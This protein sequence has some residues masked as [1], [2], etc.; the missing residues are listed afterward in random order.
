MCNAQYCW[1]VD[2]KGACVSSLVGFIVEC[3]N[4]SREQAIALTCV[5]ADSIVAYGA[6][7]N[8]C[9][10][11]KHRESADD[12]CGVSCAARLTRRAKS[13]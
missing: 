3:L 6:D 13:G 2:T 4:T 7:S 9:D 11:D 5:H 12:G 10:K 1:A 8:G